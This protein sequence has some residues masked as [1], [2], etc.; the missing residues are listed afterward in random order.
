MSDCDRYKLLLTRGIHPTRVVHGDLNE[1]VACAEEWRDET[2]IPVMVIE[3]SPGGS[4]K[5]VQTI[6]HVRKRVRR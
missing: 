4:P 6:G 3:F 1:A 5:V 2:D